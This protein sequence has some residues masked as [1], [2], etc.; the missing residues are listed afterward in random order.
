MKYV[1]KYV[2]TYVMTYF[3]TYVMKGN[4][5]ID[6]V[7]ECLYKRNYIKYLR[8]HVLL[9]QVSSLIIKNLTPL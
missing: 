6:I 5:L 9:F 3:M 4:T 2:L 8:S 1:M 7:C